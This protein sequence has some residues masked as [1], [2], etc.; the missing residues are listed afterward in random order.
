MQD[1]KTCSKCGDTKDASHYEEWFN[2]RK[3]RNQKYSWCNECRNG[4][5][6]KFPING[7]L[8]CSKC[9]EEKSSDLFT[10]MKSRNRF[11]SWCRKCESTRLKKYKPPKTQKEYRSWKSAKPE[12]RNVKVFISSH[13]VRCLKCGETDRAC[14]DFHHLRDKKFSLSVVRRTKR[15]LQEIRDEIAKC[16]VLCANCHSKLHAGRF[17]V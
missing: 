16:V 2:K 7:L 14:L 6:K 5:K 4:P 10:F 15:S 17:K 9:N 12:E 13:K 8:V 1:V 11:L 3:D